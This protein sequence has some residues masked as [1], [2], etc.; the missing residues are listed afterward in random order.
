[1]LERKRRRIINAT[2]RLRN[3]KQGLNQ[4][5]YLD[6]KLKKTLSYEEKY[7]FKNKR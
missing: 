6:K 1:M 3:L 5:M 7:I 2:Y 4:K